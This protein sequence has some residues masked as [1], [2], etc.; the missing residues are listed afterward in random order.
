MFRVRRTSGSVVPVLLVLFGLAA[1]AAPAPAQ[2]AGPDPYTFVAEW[3]IAR[4]QWP[5]F[6]QWTA[7][8][9]QPIL[10]RL[11]ADGT[12]SSWGVFESYIHEEGAMTHGAWWT[13]A[14]FAGIEKARTELLKA[15]SHP[16]AAAG[17]HRDYLLRAQIHGGRPGAVSG[18]FLHVSMQEMRPGR[19]ADWTKLWRRTSE[20][21]LADLVS[22]GALASYSV[23]SEDVHTGP[24]TMR[25]IVT[26]STGAEAEDQIE[27]AFDAAIAARSEGEREAYWSQVRETTVAESHRDYMARVTAA[28]NK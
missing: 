11:A 4:D 23:Y 8:N 3:T 1:A 14:T 17:A 7:K 13:A 26:V 25:M 2:D 27:A 15:P 18:G 20:P 24:P 9:H 12:L 6:A 16:A 22:K 19:G 21:V 28:W 5:G 10:E